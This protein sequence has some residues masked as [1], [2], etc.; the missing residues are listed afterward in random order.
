MKKNNNLITLCCLQAYDKPFVL[1][2]YDL[3]KKMP[4]LLVHTYVRD[5]NL[6][7]YANLTFIQFYVNG[8]MSLRD[9]VSNSNI[10][11]VDEVEIPPKDYTFIKQYL[12]SD[13]DNYRSALCEE[14]YLQEYILKNFKT[15]QHNKSIK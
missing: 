15:L 4:Y 8:L 10:V 12:D 3:G 6:Y 14:P 7:L 1:L 11:F 5:I 13:I 9:V 2:G